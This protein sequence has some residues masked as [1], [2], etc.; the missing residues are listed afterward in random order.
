MTSA[1]LFFQKPT[2]PATGSTHWDRARSCDRSDRPIGGVQRDELVA[3]K[4]T[5][6]RGATTEGSGDVWGYT[7]RPCRDTPTG[8]GR[9]T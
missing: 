4:S 2:A 5:R 1:V 9:V 8:P 7:V 3:T 6:H